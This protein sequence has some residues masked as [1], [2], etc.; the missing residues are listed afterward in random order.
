[1]AVDFD[2]ENTRAAVPTSE[3]E[4]AEAWRLRGTNEHGTGKPSEEVR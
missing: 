3:V 4:G 2:A 1:V